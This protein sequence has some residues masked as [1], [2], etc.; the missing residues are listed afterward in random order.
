MFELIFFRYCFIRMMYFVIGS[1]S[2]FF[3]PIQTFMPTYVELLKRLKSLKMI[4]VYPFS[5]LISILTVIMT[6]LRNTL[7]VVVTFLNVQWLI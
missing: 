7:F 2:D 4:D 1:Q 3:L 5:T 6:S